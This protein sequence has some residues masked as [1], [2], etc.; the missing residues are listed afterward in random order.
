MFDTLYVSDLA[1]MC[2]N[3]KAK[4]ETQGQSQVTLPRITESKTWKVHLVYSPSSLT[5]DQ[6]SK[7]KG[8]C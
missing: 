5:Q 8:S 4:L 7:A 6:K 2:D 3:L 1:G